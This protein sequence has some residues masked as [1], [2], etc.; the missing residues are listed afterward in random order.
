MTNLDRTVTPNPY[1]HL[2]QVPSF[3][4]TS[5]SFA[6]GETMSATHAHTS[7]DGENKSPQLAWKGFPAETKSFAVTC[8][9]P[10][11]PTPSGFWHWQVVNLPEGVTELPEDAGS[12]TGM[13]LPPAAI[14]MTNDYGTADFGG[15][16]PPP[17]DR[18]HRY[19]FAVH[20]LDTDDLGLDASTS[21]ARTGFAI[22]A[23]TI[24]RGVLT[25]LYQR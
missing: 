16:A 18:P 1:D 10:D 19:L 13:A 24:A 12:S 8:F 21:G 14:T 25:G 2:Q 3:E 6:D 7:A 23:H 17:G 4:V 11:A 9:D 5:T 15:A 22:N 20:A